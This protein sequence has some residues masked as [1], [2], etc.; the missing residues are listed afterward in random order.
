MT[1][2][3]PRASKTAQDLVAQLFGGDLDFQTAKGE[4]SR[5]AREL[6]QRGEDLL[7]DKL[8]L[9]DNQQSRDRIREQAKYA[10]MAGALAL[11]IKSKSTRK[12]AALGGLAALGSIAYKAHQRGRMPDSVDDA[13]GMLTGREAD[14]RAERLL[15]AMVAAAKADNIITPEE[16]AVIEAYPNADV[17][18]LERLVSTPAD[19]IA[20]AALANSDQ[21][22]AEIYAVSARVADGT[23]PE[24]RNYLDRLAMAL[25]LTPEA[26]ALIETEVRTG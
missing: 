25:E 13:I 17:E 14:D 10:G 16:Q 21:C 19:P 23:I 5:T 11:L 20:I 18:T 7:I 22:A 1:D 15:K 24:D 4:L 2:S 8:D 9:D 12:L 26:A 6:G 3:Q